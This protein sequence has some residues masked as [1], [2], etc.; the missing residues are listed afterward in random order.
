MTTVGNAGLVGAADSGGYLPGAAEPD[1]CAR[2]LESSATL[3]Y[4]PLTEIDWDAPLP[5][6]EYGLNPEWSTLYGTPLWDQMTETQRVT[7]TRHEAA[8]MMCTGIW[9]EMVLQQVILREQYGKDPADPKFQFALTEIADECRHSIM[10][11]R[12]CEKLG[13]PPYLPKRHVIALGRIFKSFASAEI[14]YGGALVAEEVLDVVQ[15]DLMRGENVLDIIR[16]GSKIHVVEESRHMKFARAQIRD[17]LAGAS[18]VRR[19]HSS[20][21]IAG[22]AYVIVTSLVSER[23]Y[24]AAGLEPRRA[25]AAARRSTHRASMMRNGCAGLM[26]FLGEAGLLS[27]PAVA[28]YRRAQ[29]I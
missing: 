21:A 22:A 24:R 27:R 17:H 15:R 8:S 14:A 10:F 20:V 4:D 1:L 26:D 19:R 11:A 12:A 25:V 13:V 29:M 16:T 9:L 2:L 23:V 5:D 3:S 28:L 7:L 6:H 18:A